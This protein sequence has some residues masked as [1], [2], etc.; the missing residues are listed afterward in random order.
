MGAADIAVAGGLLSIFV[1]LAL[2]S[3]PVA[4]VVAGVVIVLLGVNA[5]KGA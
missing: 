2:F 3:I 5:R 1:G 4:V